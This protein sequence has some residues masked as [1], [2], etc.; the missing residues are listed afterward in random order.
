MKNNKIELTQDL[1][2]ELFEYDS[3]TGDFFWKRK[4]TPMSR[5]VV[6]SA[7]G[8][9]NVKGYFL[10]EISGKGYYVHR[11]IWM[12]VTG[13]L[14]EYEI[15]H[16]NGNPKDNRLINLRSVSRQENQQNK[17]MYA[18]N[19]SGAVGVCWDKRESKWLV[20][21]GVNNQSA[22]I[23]YFEDWFEAVCARKSAEHKY[24]YHKNHGRV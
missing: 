22:H 10:V 6:G 2:N 16:I 3:L 1:L 20:R 23:G 18:T 17:K 21:I 8:Y 15:D 24:N 7:A 11:L 14:P 19:T 5:V 12:M 4:R 13:E 9:I